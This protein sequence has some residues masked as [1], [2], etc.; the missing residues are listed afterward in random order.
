MSTI[1]ELTPACEVVSV[2]FCRSVIESKAALMYSE[3]QL[4][5]DDA[6]D[7]GEVALSLRRLNKLAK[8]LRMSRIE[9]GALMLAS[10]EVRFN[11]VRHFPGRF[12][13]F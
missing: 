3:A 4:K 5:I 6:S 11:M 12:S 10:P 7:N 13:P 9:K 8:I 2:S 1:W